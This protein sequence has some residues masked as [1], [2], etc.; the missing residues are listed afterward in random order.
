M[1]HVRTTIRN[2]VANLLT[3]L[4]TTGARVFTNRTLIYQAHE[5]PA[6]LIT[7]NDETIT[8]IDVH[9]NMF[10]R[11]MELMVVAK[12]QVNAD[13]DDV[14]DT[15]MAEVETKIYTDLSSSALISFCKSISL[16]GITIEID[17][18]GELPI[19]QAVMRFNLIYYTNASAPGVS[20]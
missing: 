7:T 1:A 2:T 18:A 19:G 12:V 20:I 11:E 10:E 4:P 3:G 13:I 17:E 5:L 14:L 6:L 16:A 15:I 9:G 8:T